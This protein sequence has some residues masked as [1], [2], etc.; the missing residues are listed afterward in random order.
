MGKKGGGSAPAAPD[1]AKTAQAQAT[2]NKETAIA[3]SE[4]NMINQ[5]TPWGSL[6]YSQTGTSSEGT[7]QYTATTT[8]SPEQQQM[9]NLENQAGIKFGETA[10]NQLGAVSQLLSSPIDLSS[11][12]AAPTVN[13]NTRSEVLDAMMKRAQPQFDQR[14][15]TLEQNLANKGIAAGSDAYTQAMDE[16]NRAQ[17]DYLLGAQ[18]YAGSQMANEFNLANVARQNAINEMVMPRSQSLN[19]LSAMMTGSQVQGPQFVNT[20]ASSVAAPDITG[21]TYA[22]YQGALNNYNQQ[23]AAQNSMMG[24]LFGLGGTLG[25]A[26]LMSDRR[27]KTSIIKIGELVSGLGLYMYR[28]I[29]GG[30]QFVGVMADEVK[31]IMPDAVINIGGFDAVDYKKVAC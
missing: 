16:Y 9:L 25:G 22:S 13:E 6:T 8:L 30:P 29:W 2:A 31:S 23:Q 10:N 28:Y 21:S 24:G 5:K 7:P 17:N 12:G 1:P 14:R 20:P 19:E 3:Q 11:L 27:L 15:Q 26:Y 4:L 18:Q